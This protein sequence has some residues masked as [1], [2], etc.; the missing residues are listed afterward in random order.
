MRESSPAVKD[1]FSNQRMWKGT[2]IEPEPEVRVKKMKRKKFSTAERS[3]MAKR[4]WTPE[5]RARLSATRKAL[6]AARAA[7]GEAPPL[8]I[9]KAA[10]KK[11]VAAAKA[12][13][14]GLQYETPAPKPER[15]PRLLACRPRMLGVL[16]QQIRD[17][18]HEQIRAGE[19][20]TPFHTNVLALTD[21]L[22]K[23]E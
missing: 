14:A 3:A 12:V 18:L 5:A 19:E 9:S 21:Y 1:Q 17:E 10:W 8:N 23:M 4:A 7:A 16:I 11:K 22:R 2:P 13:Q 15:K 20:L 6:F